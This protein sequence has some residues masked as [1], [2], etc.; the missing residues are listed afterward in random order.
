M[1]KRIQKKIDGILDRVK[2]EQSGMSAAELGMV[3][4]IRHNEKE[5]RLTIFLAPTGRQKACC[6]VMNMAFLE[7]LE[8]QIKKEFENEFPG[9][10]IRFANAGGTE[11]RPCK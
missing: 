1:D 6:S 7:K 9:F 4:K 3:Q 11:A 10:S 8:N 5:K 2:E